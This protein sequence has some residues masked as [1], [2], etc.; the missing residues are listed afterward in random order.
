MEVSDMTPEIESFI[1][2]FSEEI[3]NNNA[4]VFAGAGFS[5]PAG[6]V[7]WKELLRDVAD[8]LQL[9]VNKEDDLVTLSQYYCNKNSRNALDEIV[10][11][12]FTKNKRIDE[13]HQIVAKLPIC[14]YWTTNYDSLIEDAL[15]QK[16]RVV[17]VKRNNNSFSTTLKDRDAIVYKMHGDKTD[18]SDVVL[19]KDDYETYYRKHKQ[20]IT[21]LTGDLI[22]KTFLFVGF[23]FNDPNLDYILSRIH[24]DYREN[25]R[26]HYALVKKPQLEDY[27]D[28]EDLFKYQETKFHL[29]IDDLKRRY[30]IHP[31]LLDNYSQ[32][33]TI[34][35]EIEQRVNSSNVF[36]SGSA[37]EYGDFSRDEAESLIKDLSKTLINKGYNIISGFGLGV[38]SYVITG[39]LEEIYMQGHK[40]KDD[41]LI[42]R[43]FPQDIGNK[44]DR[45][46]LWTK[47]RHDMISRAGISIFMFGNKL[48]DQGEVV[49]ANGVRSE[50]EIAKE[51]HNIII[52]VG[53]T[54]YVANDIWHQMK[55]HLED[56]YGPV[57]ADLEKCFDLLNVKLSNQEIIDNIMK[58]IK[59]IRK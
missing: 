2:K 40:I 28:D 52:P 42:L 54:D 29:F 56:Y 23:S 22:T 38:G 44:E 33:T 12:E 43:P 3:K 35:K 24:V 4:A 1:K 25:N 18:P 31:L 15:T 59:I 32:I 27:G 10:N 20:F 6:Y 47:Y 53:C 13:N 55:V 8:D 7:D 5:K 50:Y 51:Y 34:L 21:A 26:I 45:I 14:T 17:D 41:Q 30:N 58:I 39:A 16:G 37:H 19:I 49:K 57:N 46:K 9:D 11:N 36:I 48:N